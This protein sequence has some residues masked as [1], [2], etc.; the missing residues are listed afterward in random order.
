MRDKENE[1]AMQRL[2]VNQDIVVLLHQSKIVNFEENPYKVV[3]DDAL[4]ELA[5]SI[6]QYGVVE[7]IIVRELSPD[8][9]ESWSGENHSCR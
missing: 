1:K 5:D 8:K 4:L 9:D 7:P 6:R 3:M 2:E